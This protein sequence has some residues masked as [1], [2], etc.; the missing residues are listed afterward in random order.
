MTHAHVMRDFL[1]TFGP[2]GNGGHPVEALCTG[3]GMVRRVGSQARFF[4]GSQC[5]QAAHDCVVGM[6]LCC[7]VLCCVYM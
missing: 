4:P 1:L 6:P 5:V 2:N 7:A 3:Y